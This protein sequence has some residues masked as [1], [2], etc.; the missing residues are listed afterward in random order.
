VGHPAGHAVV[1]AASPAGAPAYGW[2]VQ[3][4]IHPKTP[5]GAETP[6][7]VAVDLTRVGRAAA[8]AAASRWDP[9]LNMLS[10]GLLPLLGHPLMAGM[11]KVAHDLETAD[12]LDYRAYTT[13]MLQ[14]CWTG[15][16]CCR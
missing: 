3:G 10:S 13:L 11:C 7:F 5:R 4:G 6:V 14:V 9:L 1:C 12:T 16:H 15:R 8:A 2:H